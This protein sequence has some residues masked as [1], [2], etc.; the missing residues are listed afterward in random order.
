MNLSTKEAVSV[1]SQALPDYYLGRINKS[2]PEMSWQNMF[3]EWQGNELAV[4]IMAFLQSYPNAQKP[5]YRM[6]VLGAG[7]AIG[8]RECQRALQEQG[9]AIH[10]DLVDVDFRGLEREIDG[11]INISLHQD[12]LFRFLQ[13]YIGKSYDFVSMTGIGFLFKP[14]ANCGAFFSPDE[15]RAHRIIIRQQL[16]RILQNPSLIQVKFPHSYL[17]FKCL[18]NFSYIRDEYGE[19]EFADNLVV[20]SSTAK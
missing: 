9:T 8:Q 13:N 4:S 18:P 14:E 1:F 19:V 7:E 5:Q 3:I 11:D 15:Y 20:F 17:L 12:N 16:P 10:L 6:L 2:R